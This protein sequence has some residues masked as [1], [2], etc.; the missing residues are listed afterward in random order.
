MSKDIKITTIRLEIGRN[1]FDLTIEQAKELQKILAETFPEKQ[2]VEIV[3]EE[4]HHYPWR[5]WSQPF[6]TL[7]NP[8]KYTEIMCLSLNK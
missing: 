4:H 3:R 6:Y 8:N 5:Y 7:E 1:K 2:K